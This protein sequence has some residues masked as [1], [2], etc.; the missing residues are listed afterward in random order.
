M[1]QHYPP[2]MELITGEMEAHLQKNSDLA[3]L[4]KIYKGILTAQLNYLGKIKNADN[5]LSVE[6]IKNCFRNN[7]YLL[8]EKKLVPD[9]ALFMEIFTAVCRA[10]KESSPAAPEPILKLPGAEAFKENKLGELL[11]AI[12]LFDKQELENYVGEKGIDKTTG[13]DR[14]IIA[15]AIFMSLAPFYSA[16]MKEVSQKVGFTI[17]RQG[18]CPICGQTAV[19]ARHRSENGARVLSCWLCHA[20]WIFPRLE[21]PYCHNKEQKKLRFFY[22]IGDKARQ[23]H[24][25]EECKFYLK[26]ID[27]KVMTKDVFLDVEALATGYLDVLARKEGYKPPGEA[28]VLN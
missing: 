1:E 3:P 17:W 8:S 22:V 23:V 5:G 18:Y 27:G 7:K 16:F 24:V 14:E 2:S 26:T 4:F 11:E 6:E 19:M 9:P 28:A 25:C 13:L 21:C 20:E 12:A 10:L 15:F